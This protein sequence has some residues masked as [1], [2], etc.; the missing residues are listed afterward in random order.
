MGGSHKTQMSY[1]PTCG[2]GGQTRGKCPV[3]LRRVGQEDVDSDGDMIPDACDACPFTPDRDYNAGLDSGP[4]R[5]GGDV[6]EMPRFAPH[7]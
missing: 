6:T 5:D 3:G 4:D 1:D 7:M 2:F